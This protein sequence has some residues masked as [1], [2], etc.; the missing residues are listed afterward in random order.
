MR[1]NTKLLSTSSPQLH[2]LCNKHVTYALL[3]VRCL[4]AKIGD[5]QH[6]L[7]L[8]YA[9]V[10]AFC[11]TWLSTSQSVSQVFHNHS[12]I[13]CDRRTPDIHGGVMMSINQTNAYSI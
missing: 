13:R 5:L 8:K 9:H 11:E 2:S 7:N 6:D 4:C 10:V 3:N 12:T 1:L